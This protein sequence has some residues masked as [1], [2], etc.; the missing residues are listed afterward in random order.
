MIS[1][2]LNAEQ[3]CLDLVRKHDHDHFMCA[4]FL[5]KLQRRSV[6]AVR[7]LNV[8]AALIRDSVR[9]PTMGR[10]R[11][12]FWIDSISNLNKSAKESKEKEETYVSLAMAER[13]HSG[14]IEVNPVLKELQIA[15]NNHGLS[16]P[17]LKRLINAR[18]DQLHETPFVTFEDLEKYNEQTTSTVLYL[19]LACLNESSLQA[20][21][22]ASHL[23]KALGLV[24]HLRSIPY[25]A[26]KGKVLLPLDLS[27]KYG[28]V[29]Q[30]LL[31]GQT[32]EPLHACVH[33]IASQAYVHL[34]TA[35]S[36]ISEL[37][38]NL[39]P[40]FLPYVSCSNNV[41]AKAYLDKLE[42]VDFNPLNKS[43]QI[44]DG[45]LPFKLW[46]AARLGRF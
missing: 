31:T 14:Q 29:Q 18:M 24:T 13:V 7:A 10:F 35:K 3:Y 25:Y 32:S 2:A 45:F 43:L 5:P 8:E 28:V 26:S 34:N 33:D 21:H 46:K 38:S 1:S 19:T 4:L 41:Y 12:Q 16:I 22:A 17:F 40:A 37:P 23:G 36:M 30:Q 44:K 6:L 27:A 39:R 15:V 9:D 20:D 11:C 42:R